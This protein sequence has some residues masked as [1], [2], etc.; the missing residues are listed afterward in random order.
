LGNIQTALTGAGRVRG[1][2]LHKLLEEVLSGELGD[3]IPALQARG[4]ELLDQLGATLPGRPDAEEM[5]RAVKRG[6]ELPEIAAVRGRLRPEWSI[7][8]SWMRD[9]GVEE[10]VVGVADAVAVEDDDS[11]SLV[12]DWK[13]DVAPDKATVAGYRGQLGDYLRATRTAKGMLVFL[14][15]GV[16]STVDGERTA[17]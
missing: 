3:D 9:D 16:I 14:T 8:R 2:A 11:V 1:L 7:S 6:L 5:A 4:S 10:V 12:V 15:T 13:S 17:P